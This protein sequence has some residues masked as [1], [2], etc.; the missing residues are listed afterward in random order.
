MSTF[1]KSQEPLII[2]RGRKITLPSTWQTATGAVVNTTGFLISAVLSWRDGPKQNANILRTNDALG[3]FS[4]ELTALMTANL[5]KAAQLVI[6]IKE[7][8][9]ESHDCLYPI[10]GV[11]L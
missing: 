6:T 9:G 2:V 10:E 7:P 1:A 5:P 8:S 11:I 3:K 4:V